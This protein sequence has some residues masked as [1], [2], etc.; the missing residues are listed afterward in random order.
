MKHNRHPLRSLCAVLLPA[1]MLLGTLSIALANENVKYGLNKGHLW[2][3]DHAGA[4]GH[5]YSDEG[6]HF[7]EAYVIS[8]GSRVTS[9]N[10]RPA[11]QWAKAVTGLQ[12]EVSTWGKRYGMGNG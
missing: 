12:P 4:Y 5:Y 9:R 2:Y 10:S 11:G 3:A 7:A 6:T 1:A 8:N